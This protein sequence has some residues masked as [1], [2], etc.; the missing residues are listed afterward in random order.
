MYNDEGTVSKT[1]EKDN[2][3]DNTISIKG[4]GADVSITFNLTMVKCE[5]YKILMSASE[6]NMLACSASG[7]LDRDEITI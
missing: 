2:D 6:K 3:A 5:D 4:N 1:L 7:E